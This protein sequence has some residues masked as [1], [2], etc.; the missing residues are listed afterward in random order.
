MGRGAS[1]TCWRVVHAIDRQERLLGL[2]RQL[3]EGKRVLN[4]KAEREGMGG[5]HGYGND[6]VSF[7][8]ISNKLLAKNGD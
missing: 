2:A 5:V 6:R 7:K 3:A 8:T 1:E 4:P